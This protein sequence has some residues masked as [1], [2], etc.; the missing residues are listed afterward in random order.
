MRAGVAF[1]AAARSSG[2]TAR[3]TKPVVSS[4]S[5]IFDICERAFGTDFLGVIEQVRANAP[6]FR[7]LLTEFNDSSAVL[8]LIRKICNVRPITCIFLNVN[9]CVSLSKKHFLNI[10]I[11]EHKPDVFLCERVHINTGSIESCAVR[12]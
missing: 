2:V 3:A 10:F 6:E 7:L 4:A 12:L 9:S 1:A 8:G 11:V 5:G